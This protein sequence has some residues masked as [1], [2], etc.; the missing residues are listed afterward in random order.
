MKDIYLPGNY[1]ESSF[2]E[3]NKKYIEATYV[4]H[5]KNKN[6]YLEFNYIYNDD[7]QAEIEFDK[8]VDKMSMCVGGLIKFY[9]YFYTLFSQKDLL[10]NIGNNSMELGNVVCGKYDFN[11]NQV[12]F[13]GEPQNSERRSIANFV[14]MICCQIVLM[15][16]LGHVLNGHTRL[17]DNLYCSG[18]LNMILRGVLANCGVGELTYALD[19]RTLEMDADACSISS[20]FVE[21]YSIYKSEEENYYLKCLQ[22]REEI[23]GIYGLALVSVFM[24]LEKEYSVEYSKKSF[25]LPN[26]C[27]MSMG[28]SIV[29]RI[30]TEM[31]P[32]EKDL[33]MNEFNKGVIEGEKIF[34]LLNKTNIHLILETLVKKREFIEFSDEVNHCWNKRIKSLLEKYAQIELYGGKN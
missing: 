11:L 24:F 31:F 29:E 2:L 27:R 1:T 18:K 9:S 8:N 19:R 3:I 33:I 15:H 34:N 26:S 5:I 14:S 7:I 21:M 25:Y 17:L 32:E 28:Y 6:R 30:V 13:S 22:Y 12:I 23:F 10:T 4:N 20:T 16:E